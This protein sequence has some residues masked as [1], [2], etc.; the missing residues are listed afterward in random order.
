M[1]KNEELALFRAFLES[2]PAETYLADYLRGSLEH[3]E[4]IM[5]SD[6]CLPLADSLRSIEVETR[7]ARAELH[8]VQCLVM[9][10]RE[11]LKST[12]KLVARRRD[13]LEDIRRAA[14][15]LAATA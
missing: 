9:A 15:T 14:R 12:E 2:I 11:T 10:E 5:R 13:E 8:H 3:F 4:Q 7:Q 1:S 6:F